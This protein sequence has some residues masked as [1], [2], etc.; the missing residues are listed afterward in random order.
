MSGG[1]CFSPQDI[2]QKADDPQCQEHLSLDV[3]CLT[4]TR[5]DAGPGAGQVPLFVLPG[6]RLPGGF[7]EPKVQ[8]QQM[9]ISVV[10]QV[11][12]WT[13]VH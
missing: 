2:L 1:S 12:I 10:H 6:Q 5:L 9:S 8:R 4:Q 13:T 7:I 3:D 11:G